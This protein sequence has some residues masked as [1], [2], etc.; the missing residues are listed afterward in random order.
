MGCVAVRGRG[1]MFAVPSMC[2]CLFVCADPVGGSSSSC[3]SYTV[4]TDHVNEFGSFSHQYPMWR[5]NLKGKEEMPFRDY[6]F[7]MNS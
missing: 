5:S 2:V 1:Y 3:V 4:G 6:T 7:E